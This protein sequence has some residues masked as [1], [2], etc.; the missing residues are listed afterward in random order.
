[1]VKQ[2]TPSGGNRQLEGRVISFR[3]TRQYRQSRGAAVAA[4]GGSVRARS[5]RP[6]DV[7]LLLPIIAPVVAAILLGL[8]GWFVA[9]LA[10]VGLPVASIVFADIARAIQWRLHCAA[11]RP[12]DPQAISGH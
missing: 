11:I 2:P 8:L 7:V 3:E 12:F 9:W 4:V 5:L 10:I 1:M 6:V